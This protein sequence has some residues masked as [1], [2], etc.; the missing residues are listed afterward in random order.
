MRFAYVLTTAA[1]FAIGECIAGS[2]LGL[3]AHAERAGAEES[4]KREMLLHAYEALHL[5]EAL[6]DPLVLIGAVAAI[7]QLAPE[8]IP[9]SIDLEKALDQAALFGKTDI[10]VVNKVDQ[11]R[12]MVDNLG[13]NKCQWRYACQTDQTC[14]FQYTC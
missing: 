9:D 3:A 12:D 7:I 10:F 5:G 8:E 11:L 1:I 2:P 14:S 4:A 13:Q 6:E